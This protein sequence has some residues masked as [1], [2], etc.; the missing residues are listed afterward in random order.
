M[1]TGKV[2]YD[3]N[4][5]IVG[6]CIR[7]Q[8]EYFVSSHMMKY[9]FIKEMSNSYAILSGA[10]VSKFGLSIAVLHGEVGVETTFKS[11]LLPHLWSITCVTF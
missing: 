10:S 6:S 7:V 4:K 8:T 1:V 9:S 11:F 3:I 2:D 5:F